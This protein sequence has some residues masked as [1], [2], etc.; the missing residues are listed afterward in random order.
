MGCEIVAKNGQTIGVIA[1]SLDESDYVVM[2]G[3]KVLLSDVY[4][5]EKLLTEFNDFVKST[6]SI[7]L[8]D[9]GEDGKTDDQ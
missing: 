5:N 9:E 1:D 8:N 4:N 6:S 7:E 2:N 3:K